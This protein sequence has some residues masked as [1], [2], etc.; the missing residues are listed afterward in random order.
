MESRPAQGFETGELEPDIVLM[1][2]AM[3]HLNGI[4]ATR[5]VVSTHPLILRGDVR[6]ARGK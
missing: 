4:E 1:D 2:I 5:P 6:A 3:S